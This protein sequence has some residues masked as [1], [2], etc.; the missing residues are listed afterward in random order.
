SPF[1]PTFLGSLDDKLLQH[2]PHVGSSTLQRG[3]LVEIIGPSDLGKTSLVS[4]LLLTTLLP[5]S[6]KLSGGTEVPLGGR[7]AHASLIFP[8]THRS[9]V[10]TL[11]KSMRSHVTSMISAA[12]ST[13]TQFDDGDISPIID[14]IVRTSLA[15]L[16]VIRIKPRW[17]DWYLALR[18]ILSPPDLT[19][20][21]SG[22][23]YTNHGMS[24]VICDGFAD[25]FWPERWHEEE[26]SGRKAQGLRGGDDVGMRDVMEMVGRLRKELGAVVVLTIQGF[27]V[28]GHTQFFTP[29]LSPPY[30]TP[31]T[32]NPDDQPVRSRDD[33]LHWPL[34]LQFTLIGR[35]RQ[36]QLPADITLVDAMRMEQPLELQNFRGLFRVS[37]SH[38]VGGSKEG[39]KFSWRIGPEG[40]EGWDDPD[41]DMGM[42]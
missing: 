23:R 36:M 30:P 41:D 22:L 13:E 14:T 32:T 10:S 33:P 38:K 21:F 1:G 12:R 18:S 11:A 6:I 3:D 42:S 39:T 16:G 35:D 26:R 7:N 20:D 28:T 29:H 24:L 31:F 37:R 4:F 5:S 17:N 25:G 9:I 8:V 15:R 34:N 40:P 2:R 19:L 27:W